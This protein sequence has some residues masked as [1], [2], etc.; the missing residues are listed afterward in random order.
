MERGKW[1]RC[2]EEAERLDLTGSGGKEQLPKA[3]QF[4]F[5]S[6]RPALLLVAF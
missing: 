1:S 2:P 3:L 6:L 5:C 4:L